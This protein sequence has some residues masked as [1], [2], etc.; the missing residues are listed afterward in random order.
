MKHAFFILVI[1]LSSFAFAARSKDGSRLTYDVSGSQTTI[2]DRTYQEVNLGVNWFFSD[3]LVWR[4]SG[5]HRQAQEQK[6][7]SGLDTSLRLQQEW[8]NSDRTLGFKIFGGPGARFAS[9]RHNAH[10]AEAGVGFRLGGLQIGGGVK[11]IRYTHS[12]EDS[13]GQPLPRNENQVFVTISGGGTL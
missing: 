1:S 3:W 12:R 11:A 9:E 2:N 7:V 13:E 10:F 6:S 8:I 5:F 4:N